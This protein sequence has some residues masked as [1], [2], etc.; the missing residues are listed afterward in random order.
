MSSIANNIIIIVIIV[1]TVTFVL[2]FLRSSVRLLQSRKKILWIFF[3]PSLQRTWCASAF[4]FNFSDWWNQ[5]TSG[6]V[7]VDLVSHVGVHGLY[8]N[9]PLVGVLW[10][11][12][13]PF[14][15]CGGQGSTWRRKTRRKTRVSGAWVSFECL[16]WAMVL[17]GFA[18]RD[19]QT[20]N[21]SAP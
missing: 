13:K 19:S 14:L 9:V 17:K 8:L 21:C 12:C 18:Q 7:L 6:F 4:V 11:I 16:T 20:P 1:V 5:T 2:S 10:F 3:S 15:F